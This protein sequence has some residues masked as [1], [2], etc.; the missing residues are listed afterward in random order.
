MPEFQWQ[1]EDNGRIRYLTQ[2]EEYRLIATLRALGF[3]EVADLCVVAVD[4]GCRRGELLSAARDQLDGKWL[5]LWKTKNGT[6]RSVPLSG[7]AQAILQARLPF[8]VKDYNLRWAWDRAKLAMGLSGDDD[9]VFHCLRHTCAT[10]LVEL[11]ANLR[12]IQAFM[13]HRAI[14]TTIRYAHVNDEMLAKAG[15]ELD[16]QTSVYLTQKVG[17]PK[18]GDRTPPKEA[19]LPPV[20]LYPVAGVLEAAE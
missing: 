12:V 20:D 8:S 4:T 17:E 7:R 16:R 11:G 10:R 14:Q 19:P 5:R 18:V 3:E 9:F 13:G 2:D 6:P 15:A 1:D